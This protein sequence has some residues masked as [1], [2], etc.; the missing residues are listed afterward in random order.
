MKG[1]ED[2]GDVLHVN[3]DISVTYAVGK[4]ILTDELE[5]TSCAVRS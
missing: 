1:A 2:G 4:M 5:F 3:E